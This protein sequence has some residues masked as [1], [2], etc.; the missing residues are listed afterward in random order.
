VNLIQFW[1]LL[2]LAVIL[3]AFAFVIRRLW[4]R[5]HAPR[6]A[7]PST[8]AARL[9]YVLRYVA[10]LVLTGVGTFLLVALVVMIERNLYSVITE[11]APAPSTVEIPP[12]LGFDVEEVTFEGGDGLRM[13]GWFAPARNGASIILLHGYG[14]NRTAM[15]WHARQLTDAGYG[16]LLYD[17][18]ASGESQGDR[19]SYGWEDPRD[20]GGAIAYLAGRAD[21]GAGQVGIAG[22]SI[23][24]QIAL[25]SAAYHPQI[26]AVWADGP[27]TVRAQD[28]RPRLNP[29]M[30][31][32]TAGNYTLDWMFAL[33]LGAPAPPPMIEIIGDIAPRP[34]MIVGGGMSRPMLGSEAEFLVKYVDYAG[35]NADLWV[36]PEAFHCD[37]PLRRPEE[38]AQRMVGFFDAAFGIERR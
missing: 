19:R 1:P 16:V 14:G 10:R 11:T 38:Y 12:D 35:D 26:G 36:I 21:A 20:V 33:R 27:S 2:E 29:L 25:Q 34:I 7:F 30:L 17:E 6:E 23:G 22:C 31:L 4:Q 15:I 32:V 3:A 18:R 9:R 37:G 8:P 5:R 28:M 13:A 24:G